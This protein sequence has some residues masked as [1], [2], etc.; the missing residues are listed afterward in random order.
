MDWLYFICLLHRMEQEEMTAATT[1]RRETICV[2]HDTIADKC[3]AP[4]NM[5]MHHNNV[6]VAAQ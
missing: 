2:S 1:S 4:H 6:G 5:Y 3:L